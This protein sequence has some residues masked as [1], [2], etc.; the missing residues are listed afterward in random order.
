VRRRTVGSNDV[1]FWCLEDV[2]SISPADGGHVSAPRSYSA[3]IG[4]FSADSA[5]GGLAFALR[6]EC[7]FE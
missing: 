5:G 2:F 6:V 1:V 7:S 4:L 3:A